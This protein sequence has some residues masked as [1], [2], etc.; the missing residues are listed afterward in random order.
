MP[1]LFE[2]RFFASATP[3]GRQA[4]SKSRPQQQRSRGEASRPPQRRG[5]RGG[6]G[7][8]SPETGRGAAS[9]TVASAPEPEEEAAPE[10]PT[11]VEIPEVISVRDLARVLGTNP[12]EIIKILMSYG[13]MANI[14]ELIDFDT[15]TIV[16]EEL[17]IEIVRE[18]IAE[19]EVE[20]GAEAPKTLRERLLEMETDPSKL[21]PRPP[22]VTVLGHVDHGKT[23]LLD[24]IRNT[25]VVAREAGGITQHIG[26]YQVELD[27]RRITFLDTPGHAAFT[28]MR[29]RGAQVT[30]IAVL[31]VAADD[32]VMPQTREAIAHARAARVPIIVALNKV[33]KPNA[34]PDR[35]KQQLADLG[36]QPE[37][38]GG[39][40]V[41]VPVSAKKR[42]NIEELLENILF[43][44]EMMDLRANPEGFAVGTIIEANQ[45]RHLGTTA[46]VLVQ[47]GTLHVGDSVVAGQQWGRVRAM[48]DADGRP[49]T[50]ATPGMPVLI[51][52]L[53][54]LP[55]A[56]DILQVVE[57]DRLARQIAAE[58][59]E[60][61]KAV[62]TEARVLSL[63]DLYRQIQSGEIKEL[64]LIVK[65]DVQ[66]SVEPIQNSLL[67]LSSDEVKVRILHID[68]GSITE[69]DVMLATASRALI[70]G[71]HTTVDPV[72][73]RYA[74]QNGV[75]I[76]LYQVIYDLIDDI[77]KAL[78]G[79]LE[80]VYEE[81]TIG[82]A[83]VRAIFPLRGNAK[84]LGCLVVDGVVRKDALVRVLRFGKEIHRGKITSLKR[85]KDDVDEIRAGYE[86]GIGIADFDEPAVGDVIE[87]LEKVRIR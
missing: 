84:A 58:R 16:G 45:D 60:K 22:V 25:N 13:T 24:A 18:T 59:A 19:P 14:N 61:A 2:V 26:A 83:E 56:G 1:S 40:T 66:G 30:D 80:P 78:K 8:S 27:G 47:K 72:A 5:D 77:E 4:K 69:S 85:Y 33:D 79:M 3:M 55:A 38:W 35:V 81:R 57:N 11:R 29:A 52:G 42:I 34:N 75:D 71:F 64:N 87:A 49:I 39:D 44:A 23:T 82:K 68:V 76:R 48:F 10:Q 31:V 53:Q 36:L 32:G 65:V 6:R 12:I 20:P 86:C 63:E 62:Q 37:E 51:S 21:K 73:R 9:V 17:G 28:A 46:T 67:Q 74:E 7:P 70:I 15:A 41:V 54:G 50:A 43:M